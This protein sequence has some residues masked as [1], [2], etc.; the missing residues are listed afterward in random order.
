MNVFILQAVSG[1]FSDW[2]FKQSPVV[3]VVILAAVVLW[4]IYTQSKKEAHE[5]E[6]RS[7]KKLEKVSDEKD[8]LFE[9]LYNSMTEWH[10]VIKETAKNVDSNTDIAVQGKDAINNVLTEMALLKKD[11]EE[12]KNRLYEKREV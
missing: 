4:W 6:D 1:G 10:V 3:V 5:R 11:L 9:R 2:L 8:K 7:E 12:I